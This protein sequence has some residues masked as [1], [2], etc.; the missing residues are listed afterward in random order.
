MP[1]KNAPTIAQTET[2]TRAEERRTFFFLAV[3]MAPILSIVLVGGYGFMIW[4]S[5]ILLG[6]PSH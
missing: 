1:H 3:L 4:M 5:Q 6:P 2:A